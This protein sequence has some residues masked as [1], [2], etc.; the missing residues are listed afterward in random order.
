MNRQGEKDKN[1]VDM[2]LYQPILQSTSSDPLEQLKKAILTYD[3]DSAR[4]AAARIVEERR[5]L[6]AALE[7]MTMAIR[8][9]GDGFS[10]GEFFLPDLVG[11]AD[12]MEAASSVLNRALMEQGIVKE[13]VGTVVIGTVCGDIHTIGKSMVA[14]MMIAEGLTVHDIGI[15]ISSEQFVQATQQLD[16]DIL[17]MSAL[18]TTAAPEMRR[19]I[20]ALQAAGLRKKVKVLVGGG[21]ITERFATGIGADGYAPT[22]PEGAKIARI[23]LGR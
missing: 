17:A 13:S 8:L 1:T 3:P 11:A 4:G 23:L 2:T 14:S 16:A 12:A 18:L 10:I 6:L 20:E 9:V 19:T 21:A 15:N 5:D 22:A 7:A